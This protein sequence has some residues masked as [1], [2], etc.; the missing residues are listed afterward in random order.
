MASD[1]SNVQRVTFKGTYNIS[2]KPSPDGKYLSYISRRDGRFQVTVTELASGDETILTDTT[3]DESPSFSPNSR[4]ILYATQVGGRGV[5][6]A[7][8]PDGRIKQKISV[9]AGDVREPTWGPFL[10]F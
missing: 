5:L 6:A 3:R 8:S 4:F 7:V 9:A 1:G 2:P 10:K